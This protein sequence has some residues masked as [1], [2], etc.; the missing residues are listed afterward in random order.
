[1]AVNY[2]S[3]WLWIDPVPD[4]PVFP[5]LPISGRP[6]LRIYVYETGL[7][8]SPGGFFENGIIQ[9]EISDQLLEPRIF[10]FQLFEPVILFYPHTA[11]FLA[12]AVIGLFTDPNFLTDNCYGSSLA[13]QDFGFPKFIDDLFRCV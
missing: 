13:K 4:K 12:P 10:L 1:V 3:G 7:K 9:R 5:R 2:A 11:I 8:V 6:D